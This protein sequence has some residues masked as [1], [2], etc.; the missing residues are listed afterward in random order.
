MKASLSWRSFVA[1]R[2]HL[3]MMV[4]VVWLSTVI[5]IAPAAA[6]PDGELYPKGL[7][8]GKLLLEPATFKSLDGTEVDG[9]TGRLV[10]PENRSSKKSNL[11]ELAFVRLK[12]TASS[13]RAPLIYL[14]G[15]PG[16]SSTWMAERAPILQGW[17]PVLAV[18]DVIFLDQRGTGRSQP[19]LAYEVD[20]GE[21]F[22]DLFADR[23]AAKRRYLKTV[24]EAA[25]HFRRAGVDFDG[26]NSVESAH[27]I[28]AVREALGYDKVCLYGFS[29]G[30]H[31]AMATMK[32]HGDILDGVIL[33]GVEPLD[34]THK[35]PLNADVQMAKLTTLVAQDPAVGSRVPDLNGL[36]DHVLA[37]LESENATV[38]VYD[39]A[40]GGL[41][42]ARVGAD[43]LLFI[44]RIDLGDASD[45]PVFP[46]LLYSINQ[47][48]YSV[49]QWF[50]QKRWG[51]G[52]IDLMPL[53][54]DGASGASKERWS[55]IAAQAKRS[56]FGDIVNFFWPDIDKATGVHD[57]G[58]DYR[59]PLVSDVR[60]LLLSGSLDYNTPPH[61]AERVRWG[62]SNAT[63]IV[64]E[65]AGHEQV[66]TNREAQRAM[67]AFLRGEDVH[68]VSA[69]WPKLRFVPLE[70]FDPEV[71]HPSAA[72]TQGFRY[73]FMTTGPEAAM[74]YHQAF[75]RNYPDF[76]TGAEMNRFGY[77]LLR[78]GMVDAAIGV[79]RLNTED[80]PDDFNT[81]DSLAEAY[82][83]KGERAKAIEYYKKS[84]S[85]NPDNKNA[86][87]MLAELG[88]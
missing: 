45:L 24:R 4:G 73:T 1:F 10:V 44:L 84:L 34:G 25:D 29:Y 22:A 42:Q 69:A 21:P 32:Y 88:R 64:V 39:D 6:Q 76:K 54:V 30:T 18:C 59:A 71:T 13:P 52:D 41:V 14:A 47:G 81:W 8:A 36:L 74:A 53:L 57:L 33:I 61:Q 38:P 3:S 37:K 46:R 83:E 62:L 26:Y 12:S 9:D 60:T 28:D 16:G 7:T 77:T 79:F 27:D 55:M 49:L 48:D 86:T 70:G 65:N 17:L 80:Y 85:L 23:K 68:G 31:L 58:E 20:S 66:Y 5:A 19:H 87:R 50:V 40:V 82:K 56:R 15:G 67:I 43:G 72:P 35:L 75:R 2:N 11:I 51:L 78:S 63:H